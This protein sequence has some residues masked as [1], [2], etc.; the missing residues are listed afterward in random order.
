MLSLPINNKNN[1]ITKKLYI[2][3]CKLI[4]SNILN[5][6]KNIKRKKIVRNLENNSK[7]IVCDIML[8]LSSVIIIEL[9]KV[10]RK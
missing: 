7:F 6:F 8:N 4:P 9:S 1:K 10:T 3:H 2:P 5:A